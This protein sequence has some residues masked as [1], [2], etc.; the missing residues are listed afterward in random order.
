M[1]VNNIKK[2][3]EDF[4]NYIKEYFAIVGPIIKERTLKFLGIKIDYAHLWRGRIMYLIL[5][6]LIGILDMFYFSKSDLG[7][8]WIFMGILWFFVYQIT[9]WVKE[10][11]QDNVESFNELTKMYKENQEM[12]KGFLESMELLQKEKK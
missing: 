4:K 7:V 1:T 12:L 6:F 8:M 3:I 9:D 11:S 10:C 2:K 5:C